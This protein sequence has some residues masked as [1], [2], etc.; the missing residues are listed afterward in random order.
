MNR[1]TIGW[2][3]HL[4]EEKNKGERSRGEGGSEN[5]HLE[6]IEKEEGEETL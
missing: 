2:S 5:L 6:E 1:W 4:G 3:E